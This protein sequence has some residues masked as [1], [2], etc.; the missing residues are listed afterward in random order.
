MAGFGSF[1]SG[2]AGGLE[3][4]D[5]IRTNRQLEKYRKSAIKRMEREDNINALELDEYYKANPGIARPEAPSEGMDDPFILRVTSK[6]K[7]MFG[8]PKALPAAPTGPAEEYGP[9]SP[10]PPMTMGMDV[11]SASPGLSRTYASSP[12]EMTYADGGRPRKYADAGAIPARGSPDFTGPPR[13]LPEE[14]LAEIERLRLERQAAQAAA[15]ANPV[16]AGTPEYTPG[17]PSRYRTPEMRPGAGA[18]GQDAVAASAR[19]GTAASQAATRGAASRAAYYARNAA[20]AAARGAARVALPAAL[21]ATA[22]EAANTDTEDYRKRFG[23]ETKDPSLLGDIGVRALGAG[24]DLAN[25][26]TFGLL[27]KYAF[28][29]KQ[30]K[31]AQAIPAPA[32]GTSTT[33]TIPPPSGGGPRRG[34]RRNPKVTTPT[35]APPEPT[36]E[37]PSLEQAGEAVSQMSPVDVPNYTKDDWADFRV[38]ATRGLMERGMSA[39][40]AFDKVD[41]QVMGLQQRGFLSF[42]KQGLARLQYGD[43]RG[44]A[45]LFRAAFQYFPTGTDVKFGMQNNTLFA[46]SID[47]KTGQPVGNPMA[48]TRE[49]VATMIENFTNPAAFR[50]WLGDRRQAQLLLRELVNVKEPNAATSREVDIAN[51]QAGQTRAQAALTNAEAAMLNAQKKGGIDVNS[52]D[53]G[54]FESRL[55]EVI[56]MLQLGDPAQALEIRSKIAQ[57]K[58]ANPDVDNETVIAGMLQAMNIDTEMLRGSGE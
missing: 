42:A 5:K 11:E 44:A 21:G 50:T 46:M 24:S 25:M 18:V 53:W 28:A 57:A 34:G 36:G 35:E 26:A 39:A 10:P 9:P 4:G 37:T 17:D 14:Q 38:K 56:G 20:G 58:M 22:Y 52:A 54:R 43:P 15:R 40:D 51:A 30:D 33:E 12:D 2:F 1:M 13:N 48:L 49:S 3:A 19:T 23:L 55:D 47:E 32:G 45:S 6:L 8:K 27:G 41:Q 29:D 31:P 7:G 16:P